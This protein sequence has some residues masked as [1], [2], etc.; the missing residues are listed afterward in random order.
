MRKRAYLKELRDRMELTQ[1]EVAKK[2]NITE[3][4]Y[5]QIENGE[6]KK[7]LDVE[8]AVKVSEIF[9]VDVSWVIEQEKRLVSECAN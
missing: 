9:G 1:S 2:L 7:K 6:R 4:Y 8:L 5:C 3:S